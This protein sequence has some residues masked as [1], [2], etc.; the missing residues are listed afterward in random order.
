MVNVAI[1]GPAGAGKS[2]VSKAVAKEMGYI[3]W[4]PGH[5]TELLLLHVSA[6][7]QIRKRRKDS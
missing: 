7:R 5:Y 6:P 3:L 2:T 4:I 1:D